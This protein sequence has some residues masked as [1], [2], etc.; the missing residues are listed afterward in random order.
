MNLVGTI[1]KSDDFEKMGALVSGMRNMVIEMGKET[2]LLVTEEMWRSFID[3]LVDGVETEL[4]WTVASEESG[5]PPEDSVEFTRFPTAVALAALALD[6]QKFPGA[7]SE[8]GSS[9]FCR[10]ADQFSLEGYGEDSVFQICEILLILGEGQVYSWLKQSG[11]SAELFN[12]L[13]QWKQL[14]QE[15][16]QSGDTRL[17]YGGDY[18]EIYRTIIKTMEG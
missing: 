5:L 12:Q 9:L 14:L 18:A 15:K 11:Q 4:Y 7:L 1:R 16:F 10:A 8:A 13:D 6:Q 2:S 3:S 17:P